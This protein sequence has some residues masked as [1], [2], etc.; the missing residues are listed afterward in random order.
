M[1]PILYPHSTSRIRTAKNAKVKAAHKKIPKGFPCIPI[2]AAI[3][4]KIVGIIA[5]PIVSPIP[6]R[7]PMIPILKLLTA[8]SDSTPPS[9]SIPKAAPIT[10]GEIHGI[11]L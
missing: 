7:G 11:V 6:A 5:Q 10:N 1:I 8:S 3:E 4:P 2:L 9:S